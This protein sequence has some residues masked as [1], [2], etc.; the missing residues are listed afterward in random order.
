MPIHK[1]ISNNISKWEVRKRKLKRGFSLVELLIV[2]LLLGL[3]SIVIFSAIYIGLQGVKTTYLRIHARTIATEKMEEL[4][5]MP[6]D[7]LTTQNGTIVPQGSIPDYQD[8]VKA[9]TT[10]NVNIIIAYVDDPF[11][12]NAEGTIPGKP[13]DIYPYD[14]KRL[15]VKVSEKGKTSLLAK[16]TSDV[17]AK[18]AETETNTGILLVK[19]INA[20]GN[21]V[22]LAEVVINNPDVSLN[23]IITSTDVDG[24][25]MVPKLPPDDNYEVIASLSG[26][27]TEKTYPSTID[28]PNPYIRNVNILVQQVANLT[29]TIDKTANLEI[30]AIDSA[31]LTP[32]SGISLTT[33]GD[34]LI[35]ENPNVY[36]YENTQSTNFEG[37]IILSDIEWDSYIITP[38][39]GYYV[40]STSPQ[41]KISLAPDATLPVIVRLTSSLTAPTIK[42][43]SPKIAS[44]D[45][46]VNVTID[47]TNL[48]DTS[49]VKLTRSG[50]PSIVA[51]KVVAIPDNTQ[52]TA[53]FDLT[54]A[55]SDIWNLEVKNPNDEFAT[56]PE[57]FTI[58]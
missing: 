25:V 31:L 35:Y 9:N 47:G 27:S 17:S 3:I 38:Q 50:K 58:Q 18:A 45:S 36:K 43:H 20:M 22:P 51:T 16:L 49:T 55:D 30:T 57:D 41:Q 12:G 39:T 33:R 10:F 54:G 8:V 44:S 4:K 29:L 1:R 56:Q 13:Q 21:P 48:L 11:D 42:S 37:K 6:Y 7:L 46:T 28:N 15:E 40:S 14:Y 52:L 19:V 2:I 26:Y 34:K 32:L 24:K 53:T 5:N 23:Q